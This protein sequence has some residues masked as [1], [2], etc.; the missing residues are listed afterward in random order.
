[1]GSRSERRT[2]IVLGGLPCTSFEREQVRRELKELEIEH[3]RL[4][5][6]LDS[7]VKSSLLGKV[8][9]RLSTTELRLQQ[10]EED[11][12]QVVKAVTGEPDPAVM[13]TLEDDGRWVYAQDKK[14]QDA[15]EEESHVVLEDSGGAQRGLELTQEQPRVKGAVI[16]SRTA[17]DPDMREKLVNAARTALGV[18]SSRV[19]VVEGR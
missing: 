9:M 10:L 2:S 18:P 14:L 8:R 5:C 3:E 16:V 6:Q 17:A 13:V 19:C 15:G 1:M 7:P 4:E 12:R 11:L